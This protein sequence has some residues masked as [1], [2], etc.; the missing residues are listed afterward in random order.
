MHYS[1]ICTSSPLPFLG[2]EG[3][4]SNCAAVLIQT[5]DLAPNTLRLCDLSL[6]KAEG[7]QPAELETPP[8]LSHLGGVLPR[9]RKG[10]LP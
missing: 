4:V 3:R 1:D 5:R 7:V 10:A 9:Y 6:R 2:P 8:P